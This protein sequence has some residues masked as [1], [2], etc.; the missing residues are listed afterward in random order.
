MHTTSLPRAAA[1]PW[2]LLLA[3]LVVAGSM[4][5]ANARADEP[6]SD[7]PAPAV[8]PPVEATDTNEPPLPLDNRWT[9]RGV[10][11][12][13][14]G[15]VKF[16]GLAGVHFRHIYNRSDS[17]LFDKLYVSTGI[18]AYINPSTPGLQAWF[19]W[20]PIAFFKV[21]VAYDGIYDTGAELGYGYGLVFPSANAPF[22]AD[23]LEAREGQEQ[24]NLTHRLS[25][26][27]TVQLKAG[28]VVLLNELELGAWYV[29]GNEGEYHYDTLYDT[30]IRRG[31]IDGVLANRTLLLIQ[32]WDDGQDARLLAGA[33]NQVVHAFGSGIE[34]DRLG[35]AVI[36]TPVTEIWG[37]SRPTLLVLSGATMVDRNR[38][39]DFWLEAALIVHW[40]FA[41]Y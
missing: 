8:D 14:V 6:P 22:D 26:T 23:T 10:L 15:P 16:T 41:E 38:Q 39:Y 19:E 31:E 20:L 1:S 5:A 37:I 9:L 34:R 35:G 36:Y 40:D 3:A 18:D 33:V 32:A 28:P 29:P 12:G 25:I 4:L 13:A 11:F 17:I 30:L 27:P 2:R 24:S 7:P 21:K